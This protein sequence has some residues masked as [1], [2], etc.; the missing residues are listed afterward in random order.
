MWLSSQPANLWGQELGSQG[1]KRNTNSSLDDQILEDGN[2][3]PW[4]SPHHLKGVASQYFAKCGIWRRTFAEMPETVVNRDLGCGMKDTSGIS[5]NGSPT[6]EDMNSYQIHIEKSW[7]T[8]FK[9]RGSQSGL[10]RGWS[11]DEERMCPKTEIHVHRL[12]QGHVLWLEQKPLLH[13]SAMFGLPK[14]S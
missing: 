2:N 9:S 7:Q 4:R 12:P 5:W 1:G 14:M 6:W 8:S 11:R 3:E 13:S 10:Q